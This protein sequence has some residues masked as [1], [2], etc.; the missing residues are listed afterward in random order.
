MVSSFHCEDAG[1][2]V[3]PVGTSTEDQDQVCGEIFVFAESRN[4]TPKP[5]LWPDMVCRTKMLLYTY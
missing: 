1:W 2:S 5:A 3:V 4:C